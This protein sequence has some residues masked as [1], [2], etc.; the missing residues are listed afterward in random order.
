[1]RR[2]HG[3]ARRSL[4]R[5]ARP[6]VPAQDHH[7]V[8]ALAHEPPVDVV[9]DYPDVISEGLSEPSPLLLDPE[10]ETDEQATL[11]DVP[12]PEGHTCCRTG[13]C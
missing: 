3:A 1:M 11:F 7:R 9:H 5:P 8:L 10:G 2:A 12:R 13:R 6:D 4:E